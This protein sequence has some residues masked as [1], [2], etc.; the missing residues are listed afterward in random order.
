VIIVKS[1]THLSN[2]GVTAQALSVL[3]AIS[4]LLICT[5]ASLASIGASHICSS[6]DGEY[7]IDFIYDPAKALRRVSDDTTQPFKTLAKVLLEKTTKVCKS[8]TSNEMLYQYKI[9]EERYL[10]QITTS[11]N[12]KMFL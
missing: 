11:L 9:T 10:I 6:A 3:S 1:R 12:G 8:T 5:N 2:G 7:K 4:L